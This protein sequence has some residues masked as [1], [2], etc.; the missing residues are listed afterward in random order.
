MMTITFVLQLLIK[1]LYTTNVRSW[2]LNNLNNVEL[3]IRLL[4]TLSCQMWPKTKQ[5]LLLFQ[6]LKARVV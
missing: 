3:V 6:K 2:S 4:T 1:L 5:L